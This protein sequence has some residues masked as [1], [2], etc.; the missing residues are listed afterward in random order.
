MKKITTLVALTLGLTCAHGQA[1]MLTNGDFSTCDFTGWEKDTDGFGDV[2]MANDFAIVTDGADCHGAINVD[3]YEPAG[4]PFGMPLTEAFFAN[5][6]F[7]ALDFT[8]AMDSTFRLNIDFYVD[9][10]LTSTDPLFAADYFLIGLNDGSGSYFDASGIPGFIVGPTDIDGFSSQS[11]S[12]ELDN[13][14]ANQ[15]GWFLDFQLNIGVD[16]FGFNDAFGSQ[17]VLQS[18]SLE[19]V[20]SGTPVDEPNALWLLSLG[21]VGLLARQR[22]K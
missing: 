21:A 15:D 16:D 13:T 22:R 3:Y 6:L 4:D 19:E 9:S 17:F 10:E 8:A 7:Q 20:R 2:S 14:F 11:L 1:A 18:V 12:V 5:T